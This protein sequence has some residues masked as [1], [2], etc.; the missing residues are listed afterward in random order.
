MRVLYSF[1]LGIGGP[2]IASTAWQQ[3]SGL[4]AAGVEVDV[5]AGWRAR[6]FDSVSRV[7]L[8]ETLRFGPFR[9][10][11]RIL[12]RQGTFALHDYLTAKWLEKNDGGIDLFHGW[13]LASMRTMRVARAKGIPCVLERPNA[14]TA[15]AYQAAAEENE[16]VGIEL[17]KGHDHAFNQETLDAETEEYRFCDYL[18]CPSPFVEKTFLD[19]DTP[20]KK[21]LRHHY[22]FDASRFFPPGEG[23][24]SDHLTVIYAG[25]CEPRKGLHHILEAWLGSSIH[26]K[27]KLLVCGSFVEGYRQALEPE[28]SHASVEILGHRDDLPKLMRESDVFVLSSVEEGSALVTYEALG[29][30]CALLVSDATGAPA[31]H[32]EEALVHAAGD[33]SALRDH[34]DRI[35][36]DRSLLSGMQAAAQKRA[37]N[38]SWMDAGRT[39]FSCYEEVLSR[40]A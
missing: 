39:L 26:R 15:F 25:V 31:T 16:K 33:S 38:L 28:V 2:R 7:A 4:S 17:P 35:D 27:G 24:T 13:P 32:G 37:E 11:C 18:T 21:I 22:G 10:P 9:L 5:S 6:G 3:V 12:G 8:R 29:S 23:R 30:G 40:K 34:F 19:K 1:P 36:Q 14:H 20:A